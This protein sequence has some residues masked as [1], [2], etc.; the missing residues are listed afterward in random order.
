MDFP[1][2]AATRQ[3]WK[4]IKSLLETSKLVTGN[5]NQQVLSWINTLDNLFTQT[6]APITT[7]KTG[8]VGTAV[9]VSVVTD[10][11]DELNDCDLKSV[12]SQSLELLYQEFGSQS[13]DLCETGY[14]VV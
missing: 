12:L 9:T 3:A 8:S 14:V 2:D 5:D 1:N 6:N 4:G 13:A 7:S 10:I 11:L